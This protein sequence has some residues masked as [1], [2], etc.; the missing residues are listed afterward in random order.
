MALLALIVVGLIDPVRLL[1]VAIAVL[2]LRAGTTLNKWLV[3]LV[4][5][6][7]GSV[8][9]L[10]IRDAMLAGPLLPI[11]YVS[12]PITCLIQAG[13]IYW[14]AHLWEKRKAKASS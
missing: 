5:A 7:I 8:L 11:L 9:A 6:V 14:L 1:I 3:I 4:S 2:T 10:I 12:T 13:V